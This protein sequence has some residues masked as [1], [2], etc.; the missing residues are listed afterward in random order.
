MSTIDQHRADAGRIVAAWGEALSFHARTGSDREAAAIAL[1]EELPR[2]HA[3]FVALLV[4]L[5]DTSGK[6]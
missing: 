1:A 2:H 4:R 3:A 6:P 5:P